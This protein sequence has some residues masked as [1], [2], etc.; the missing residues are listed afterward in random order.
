MAPEAVRQ[1][2]VE[3]ELELPTATGEVL[4]ELAHRLVQPGR[5]LQHAGADPSGQ[6]AQRIVVGLEAD[7]DD[8]GV[9]GGQ[10]QRA[11]RA[12]HGAVRDVDEALCISARRQRV[13]E[14]FGHGRGHV[15]ASSGSSWR[16]RVR[17][18]SKTLRRAAAGVQWSRTAMSS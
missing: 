11:G 2:E 12:V 5:P 16:R 7:L 10:E 4:L 13:G 14:L 8:A 6:L 3:R 17:S 15:R 18:P 1:A 9:G